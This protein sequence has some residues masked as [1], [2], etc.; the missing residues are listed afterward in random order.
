MLIK[1]SRFEYYV[2]V[3]ESFNRFE[4][5]IYFFFLKRLKIFL[6]VFIVFLLMKGL[7]Y[8]LMSGVKFGDCCSKVKLGFFCI[9]L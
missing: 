6:I 3:L 5:R 1:G 9:V 4:L 8:L 7:L 2:L